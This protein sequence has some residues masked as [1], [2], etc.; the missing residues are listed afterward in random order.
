MEDVTKSETIILRKRPSQGS[1]SGLYVTGDGAIEG[2]AEVQLFMNG[3]A[4]KR[5]EVSGKVS[6]EW[7]GDWYA[8][9]AEVRYISDTA[10]DGTITLTYEFR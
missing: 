6:F 1:I 7:D 10:V 9:Q 8:D 4:Y 2:K 5:E 3:A